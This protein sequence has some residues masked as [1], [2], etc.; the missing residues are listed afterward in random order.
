MSFKH[1]GLLHFV[2]GKGRILQIQRNAR[3][4]AGSGIVGSLAQPLQ[5]FVY[6]ETASSIVLICC[7]LVA[8]IWANSPWSES[9]FHFFE[10][11]FVLGSFPAYL[12][13][14]LRFWINDGLMALFFLHAGLEIKREF[15]VGELSSFKRASLP[16][17]ATLGGAL[18]PALIYIFFTAGTYASKGWGIATGTDIA[19]GLGIFS[20]LGSRVST[21]LKVF[22][23]ALAIFDDS[24]AVL[25][26][27]IF[28]THDLYLP[29]LAVAALLVVCLLIANLLGVRAWI[30]YAVLGFAL[31]I[32]IAESG[33]HATIAGVLL[34]LTIPARAQI[35]SAEFVEHGH[36]L[37]NDF[38]ASNAPG[39][40]L[41]MND[42]QETALQALENL[43]AR[44]Q[45]P[46]QR[47]EHVLNYLVGFV[48]L[49]LFIIANAGFNIVDDLS[50]NA[51]LNPVTIGTAVGLVVGKQIGVT[52][53]SWLLTRTG[54]V[55][56]PA[57]VSWPQIYGVGWFCGIGFTISLFIASLA[58]GE[59]QPL[60]FNQVKFGILLATIISASG[61]Y[62]ILRLSARAAADSKQV[63]DA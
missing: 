4:P 63:V 37:L 24:I 46:L 57:D 52:L 18:I 13:Q 45:S 47:M 40:G 59:S 19:F 11:H 51:L 42:R 20:L 1:P 25:D 17:V 38:A 22:F 26:I 39:I 49:P 29:A 14:P 60:L 56:L 44:I 9:Y 58:F 36:T 30:V 31:W 21:N 3:K 15:L 53:F 7:T 10:T 8:L 34:A 54:W 41:Y 23:I 12:D 6:V 5:E 55:S 50:T 32:A 2:S 48:V 43:V 35:D 62:L 28:Y 33:V 61:G 16:V 27:T